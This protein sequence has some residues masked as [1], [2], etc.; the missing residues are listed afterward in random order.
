MVHRIDIVFPE[1]ADG[2]G[3][4][5]CIRLEASVPMPYLQSDQVVTINDYDSPASI[6]LTDV[7]SD[8]PFTGTFAIRAVFR[9]LLSNAVSAKEDPP[10]KPT[11]VALKWARGVDEVKQLGKE[12]RFYATNLKELMDSHV[13]PK[14][15]GY[16]VGNRGGLSIACL[17]LDWYGAMPGGY[18]EDMK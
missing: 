10:S 17:V 6:H 11:L 7:Q 2:T 1:N 14:C 12:A 16:F 4:R 9:A 3:I 18:E 8:H 15:H 5:D 13:V